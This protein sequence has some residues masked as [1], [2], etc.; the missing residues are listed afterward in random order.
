MAMREYCTVELRGRLIDKGHAADAVTSVLN[1]LLADGY[2]SEERFAEVS[3]RSRVKRGETP[4]V[5]AMKARRKG[6]N[7]TALAIALAEAEASFD[8]DSACRELLSRR[9]PQGLYRGDS[10]IWQ[11]HA[12][13]LQNKGFNTATILRVM[14]DTHEQFDN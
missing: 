6:V 14:N 9:D 1:R 2:L 10:R 11:R 4:R 8:A 3:I 12:R 5:A 13:F 7:E